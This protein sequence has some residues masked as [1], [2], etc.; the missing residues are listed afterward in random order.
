MQFIVLDTLPQVNT[1]NTV[2][3]INNN[4]DDWFEFET[5][6][7]LFYDDS[8]SQRHSLGYVKIG[9]F[10]MIKGQRRA[11]L[12]DTF[13]DLNENFFSLGQDESYY[14][15]LK[16]LDNEDGYKILMAL[17]DIAYNLTLFERVQ[18][19]R[20]TKVSL[21]RDVPINTVKEQFNRLAHGGEELTDY[22]F[23]YTAPK[24]KNSDLYVQLSFNV[25]AK[26]SPPTNVHVIIGRNGVGKT[27]LLNNI[28]NSL[29]SSEKTTKY[30]IFDANKATLFANIVSVSFSAFD[31]TEPIK[32]QKDK[33]KGLQYSYIGLKRIKKGD[34][35]DNSPKSP[36][37]LANEFIK[38]LKNCQLGTKKE[39]WLNAI[40]ILKSDPIFQEANVSSLIDLDEEKFEIQ[41]KEIFKK[42]S[43]GHK[44]VLL[45]ITRLV[46][47]VKE[48]TL[49][50]L[51][52]PESHLHPP[53][54]SAFI[55]SL[56]E[57]L[58][59]RNG[60]AI[61]ATH[62]PVILQEVPKS[63]AWILNRSGTSA[64]AERLERET[65]GENVGTLTHDVF[66]LEV[67]NAGFY[68][69]LKTSV[70]ENDT[71]QELISSFNNQLGTEAKAISRAL[72]NIKN[73][74]II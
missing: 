68:G 15:I 3:L 38:S 28:L 26:S 72:I 33:T 48:K 18:K 74:G 13:N 20:V 51:D 42:L 34:D 6:Y 19:E 9:Q 31:E 55:R 58:I 45:T 73:N 30:G 35:K 11:S 25:H 7:Q 47:T 36:L 49:V 10:N 61:I 43:S 1:S 37:M 57:L 70:N 17:N 14:Q 65:F 21:L 71:Y 66:G 53:L 59:L 67:T 56:S 29:L 60:V 27:H 41:T 52:E 22:D 12:S 24:P 64:K 39:R 69:L 54:L 4:W 40:N 63:C 32:E 46:E 62:S 8:N 23:T 2:Y 44:I 50:M 5:L 16:D